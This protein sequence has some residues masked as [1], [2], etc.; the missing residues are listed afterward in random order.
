MNQR[1]IRIL[2]IVL[3]VICIVGIAI[4]GVME[5]IEHKGVQTRNVTAN[6]DMTYSADV[7]T[8][9][10]LLI[11]PVEGGYC[12][13][14]QSGVVFKNNIYDIA[15]LAN[16]GL[17][18]AQTGSKQGF[19]NSSLNFVFITDET[20]SSNLSEDF[21]IY[22]RNNK[23]GFINI[24][25][26]EKIEA[27]YDM[28]YDFSEGL[29]AVS[30]DG[31]IG[32]IN[33]KGELIVPNIYHSSGRHSFKSGLCLVTEI[34]ADG[35]AGT[36]YYI[37][38]AG[39]KVI[40]NGYDYGMAFYEN[41][42]FVKTGEIWNLI[43]EKGNLITKEDFGPYTNSVPG[44]F[45]GG[46]AVVVKDGLYG[47]INADGEY[48]VNPKHEFISDITGNRTVFKSG[49][50]FGYMN[51]DGSVVISPVYESL[52]NFK[53]GIATYS[54][55]GK[56]G[57]IREDGVRITPPEYKKIEILDN[58]CVKIYTDAKMYFYTDRY[59]NKIWEPKK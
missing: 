18:Y 37:D 16:Y 24:K 59:G 8:P 22:K 43:D 40:D 31:K 14:N 6:P 42:T 45:S 50:K 32:F 27:V 33:T 54:E 19:L 35:S 9:H 5:Y 29:A 44:K 1:Y 12:F 4:Y 30:K 15:S 55:Q 11:V 25:T 53:F 57:V 47:I 39:N 51:I 46:Y 20:I 49:G 41:R 36:S 2:A 21:V 56:F 17:Y 58:S 28:V 38:K 48:V 34:N 13:A 52:G 10:D 3:A 7:N 26:G 23:S